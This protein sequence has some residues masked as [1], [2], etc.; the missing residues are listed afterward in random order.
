MLSDYDGEAIDIAS[1]LRHRLK[2]HKTVT[3]C[4]QLVLA[5]EQYSFEEAAEINDK[6]MEQVKQ[7]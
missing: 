4:D 2:Q 3:L 1:E 7:D 6:I 5:L